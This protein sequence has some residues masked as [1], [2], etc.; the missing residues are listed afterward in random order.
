MQRVLFTIY[1]SL[2]IFMVLFSPVM[3]QI[4]LMPLGDSI[5]LGELL[6]VT[7]ST[8][9]L[10]YKADGLRGYRA[11][12]AAGTLE[13]GNGGY[14]TPLFQMLVDA[15]WDLEMVGRNTEGGG[16]HEGYS[17]Y[18]STDIHRELSAMLQANH[19]DV[20]L[21]HIGTNDLPAPI[22]PDSCLHNIQT[23]VD[24]IH[25]F[26]PQIQIILARIIP[27][28]QNTPLGIQRY[29]AIIE[30]NNLI[31][32]VAAQ[33]SNVHLV[34]MWSA[35][36]AISGWESA[37]MSDSWHPNESGYHLMAEKWEEILLQTISGR[38]PIIT[39]CLPN[40]GLISQNDFNV[41]IEGNF[42]ENG[43][44][45][46]LKHES[47]AQILA[48]AINFENTNRIQANFD[49][50]QGFIGT[51][52]VET[53]NPN[54][55]RGSFSS[56]ILFDIKADSSLAG[57]LYVKHPV[58][59]P[60]AWIDKNPV[61]TSINEAITSAAAGAQIRVAA[62][63]FMENI[64]LKDNVNLYGGFRGT[65]GDLT[66]REA[67]WNHITRTTINGSNSGP[68]LVAGANSIIDG[69][70]M[71]NGNAV[72]GAGINVIEKTNVKINNVYIHSCEASWMGGGI[73]VEVLNQSGTIEIDRALVWKC[74][75]YCG[76]L[77]INELTTAK[78]IVKNSSIVKND[79][80]GLELPYHDG[81][82]PATTH[83]FYNCI[84]WGNVNSQRSSVY[85]S[86]LYAWARNYADY[87]YIGKE[88]WPPITGKWV[89]PLPHIIFE[90][91]VG[92]PGFVD[93]ANGDFHLTA[94]SP[95]IGK[96]KNGADLGVFQYGTV[97]IP[98]GISVSTG[99][100]D[101]GSSQN[102]LSFTLSNIGDEPA[103]WTISENPEQ[104]WITD[105]T[106]V[107]GTLAGS[108]SVEITVVVDRNSLTPGAYQGSLLIHSAFED[109]NVVVSLN[110]VDPTIS[111]IRINAGGGSYQDNQYNLWSA[112][113]AYS[114]GGFGYE[115]G[116]TY[117]TSHTISGTSAQALYKSERWGMTAYR[118]DVTNGTYQ[119]I[120]HFAEVYCTQVDQRKMSVSIEGKTV[121]S[122][123]DIF[124]EVGHDVALSYTFSD[125]Q[126]IDGRLDIGFSASIDQAKISAI[127]VISTGT[128]TPPSE[129]IL[130]VSVDTLKLGAID[131][132]QSLTIANTGSA[133]LNWTATE[134]P[135][136]GWLTGFSPAN[137]SI[138]NGSSQNISL[139]VDRTGLVAGTYSTI[140]EI[141][142]NGGNKNVVITI[143]VPGDPTLSV[144]ATQ[145]DFGTTK[146]EMTLEIKNSGGGILTWKASCDSSW[147]TSITPDT[148]A[149][150][151]NQT[152]NL[153][154]KV[155]RKNLTAGNYTGAVSINANQQITKINIMLSVASS[156]GYSVRL[157]AGGNNYTDAEGK[158]WTADQAYSS[159]SFGY[160]NGS[161]YKT[162]DAISGTTADA[163]YQTER[164]GMT[165][166]QF[167]VP[168]GTYQVRLHLAEIYFTARDRRYMDVKIEGT[169]VLSS[170][171][172]YRQVGHDAAL[173][174]NYG[175][176]AV[177]DGRLDIEFSAMKD[178]AKIS[179]I[180]VFASVTTPS[181]A[182]SATTLDFGTLTTS[183]SFTVSNSGSGSLNWSTAE[184]PDQSWLTTMQPNSG[185]LTGGA[186]QQVQ[187][188]VD[189]SGLTDGNYTGLIDII[190]N[191]GN[192][193]I[194]V[195][196]SVQSTVVY[197]QRVNCGSS[198]GYT[199]TQGR[200]WLAD[201][202][203]NTGS[204][205]YI[206]GSRYS[207]QH[208]IGS[209][210]DDQLYQSERWGLS[211]YQFDVPN[212]TYQV[213]L[214]FAELYFTEASKRIFHVQLEGNQ[215]LTRLDI[216]LIAGHDQA[217]SYTYTVNVT[218]GQLNIDFF[219]QVEDPKIS[220]IQVVG[221]NLNLAKSNGEPIENM[222]V[223]NPQSFVLYQNY[224]NP[225]NPTTTIHYDLP[226]EA[227]VTLKIFNLRGEQLK[228]L[229]NGIKPAGRHVVVWNSLNEDG[230]QVASGVYFY[231][232]EVLAKDSDQQVLKLVKQMSF[233]K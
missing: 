103:D 23:I 175:N 104:T 129:P 80:F 126:V 51:W 163:L 173:I 113:Q 43:M 144:S 196:L 28:L 186:S 111:A 9:N 60:D 115:N 106:P 47:G 137:G 74:R 188:T 42:F 159:G 140:L 155:D 183:L 123:L 152:Q 198:Y 83:D 54:K 216:Y 105:V 214:L 179:A 135:D 59:S 41:A 75:S 81:I 109:E 200:R 89:S 40:S 101:F 222:P 190:S 125:I 25:Q 70:T 49:L 38:A 145:L 4:K 199:D 182:V 128:V 187:V 165:A 130:A 94:G 225:F 69:F 67:V 192:R 72:T 124:R 184:N 185:T 87:S 151:L 217:L 191:G 127:E 226:F 149:L 233:F 6:V 204:W 197:E 21:L 201:Q 46:L 170:L 168:D 31:G 100:L 52:L 213:T 176:I 157:N 139:Q 76:A 167:D 119:V 132:V 211:A 39:S 164:W 221:T 228:V 64:V 209:T 30:L 95:C 66:E 27:C 138:A 7:Q 92:T 57:V 169:Q 172:I 84:V 12:G 154:I 210:Q 205:G 160:V 50:T 56:N 195:S 29:P 158:L 3:A 146:T 62:G 118:F 194:Q 223:D 150:T 78:V 206:N 8:Y 166:Y 55:M 98:T 207:T 121:L 110:V 77:E 17:G 232:L 229:E 117:S 93:V 10:K 148:G 86:D 220:A 219:R 178:K 18:M 114:T 73:Y 122:N 85:F 34:D 224:P 61:F 91:E 82:V 14:R 230:Q 107:S 102:T 24:R 136:L 13:A 108:S 208:S 171:D 143:E 177:N 32:Q 153:I 212:G 180:E 142:S 36:T 134:N 35:F 112:D 15:G 231:Q 203:Y 65:E 174:Y 53:I 181:L 63:E 133:T 20:V 88:K 202:T 71:K 120:L 79:A 215:V 11:D 96:G 68:C 58:T 141:S 99:T 162:T 2:V 90:K 161:S 45:A 147:I 227:Q 5:T 189:R 19:P 22:D 16:N 44:N 116:Q 37:L 218:D 33:W 131:T 26:D 48:S 1:I 156:S 97:V 193:Q